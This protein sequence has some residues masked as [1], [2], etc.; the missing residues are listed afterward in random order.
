MT[1]DR[2]AI[3]S[4]STRQ[5]SLDEALE[6]YA[7][8]GF[9]NVEFQLAG[10][11]DWLADGH[12]ID[13]GKSLLDRLGLRSIG[14]FQSAMLVFAGAQQREEVERVQIENAKILAELGGGVIVAGS[15]GPG[16]DTDPFD[17]LDRVGKAFA[18]LAERIDPS[19]SLA[20]EFNWG[21]FVTSIR[22]AKIVVDA[23]AHPRVG[24]LFDPAHYHCTTSKLEDLTEQVI[25]QISHVHMNDMAD[26]PGEHCHC[27]RDR[28]LP[29]QGVV[30]LEAIVRR[31][32][33][34]GYRGLYSIEMF[35]DQLWNTPVHD[36]AGQMYES[37]VSLCERV[38][39]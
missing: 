24:I 18:S 19:V 31:L 15:D 29:G 4:V 22:S 11:K 16:D 5:Q 7:A 10:L 3:N 23:A 25:A 30:A 17:G 37:M 13:D 36:A 14:G 35:N 26:K 1:P 12:S 32:E 27:N 39:A 38:M 6:A 34:H 8:V 9:R 2:I 28:V 21:P 20:I 33:Q